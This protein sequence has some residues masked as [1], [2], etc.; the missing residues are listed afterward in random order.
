MVI[1]KNFSSNLQLWTNNN[2]ITISQYHNMICL[3]IVTLLPIFLAL[4]PFLQ[5]FLDTIFAHSLH[6]YQ[7]CNFAKYFGF[8]FSKITCCPGADAGFFQH[9]TMLFSNFVTSPYNNL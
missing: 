5:M 6:P 7:I 9:S 1:F 8:V 3:M 2:N 4:Y